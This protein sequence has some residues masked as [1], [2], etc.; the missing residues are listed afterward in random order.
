MDY[1]RYHRYIILME[2]ENREFSLRD[3]TCRGHLK[4]ET[5]NNKGA[6][7]CRVE[8]L[9]PMQKNEYVYK[10]IFFGKKRERTIAAVIGSLNTN[11]NGVGE[12]YFRFDPTDMDGK[13]H[14]YEEFSDVIV[15]AAS[16]SNEK[17]PLHPVLSGNTGNDKDDGEG[18]KPYE[19]EEAAAG[20]EEYI[21]TESVP[22][23]A[24]NKAADMEEQAAEETDEQGKEPMEAFEAAPAKEQEAKPE[25]PEH[26]E[27]RPV[28]DK[29]YKPKRVTYNR[30]YNEHLL[31]V[32]AH[33]CEVADYYEEL[34]PFRK[35][36]LE[37]RWRKIHHAEG[38]PMISPG[39]LYFAKKYKHYLFGAKPDRDGYADYYYFAVP[40]RLLEEE[41]P[42]GGKSGFNYWQA[43]R[44]AESEQGAY[45]YW[46][47]A[48]DARTG[49]IIEVRA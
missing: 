30:Y 23:E 1:M 29:D 3:D 47:A 4:I 18:K 32:C 34:N 17:E 21:D 16:L 15:A 24:E 6:L 42:D 43:I 45:G 31:R 26:K 14:S 46:I 13:G 5:G 20:G 8:N 39:A 37:A 28:Q 40:G 41:R 25:K 2:G 10:L 11:R 33:M 35:D 22:D 27:R 19:A 44:G 7:R 9:K 12:T 36:R 48:I 38:F 49:D